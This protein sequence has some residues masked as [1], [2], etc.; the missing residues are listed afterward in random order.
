MCD[1]G[2]GASVHKHRSLLNRLLKAKGGWVGGGGGRVRFDV[3][4]AT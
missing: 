3:S 2:E 4:K 1:I